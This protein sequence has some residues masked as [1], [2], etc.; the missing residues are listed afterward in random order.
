MNET[1]TNGL[2]V[3]GLISVVAAF[4]CGFIW[5]DYNRMLRDPRAEKLFKDQAFRRRVK[6]CIDE[7]I[8]Q[9]QESNLVQNH[10]QFIVEIDDQCDKGFLIS[11]VQK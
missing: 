11:T 6:E 8:R 2:I 9:S 10:R 5:W 7:V 3:F 4:I 1:V